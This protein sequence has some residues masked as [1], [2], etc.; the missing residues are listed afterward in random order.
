MEERTLA[1]NVIV[2]NGQVLLL[3]RTD[4]DYWELPGGTVEEGE[5]PRQAAAREA[6]EEMG[7]TVDVRSPIG[8]LDLDFEHEGTQYRFRGFAAD[9]V[10]GRPEP[11]E[12]RF[13]QVDW[14]DSDALQRIPLA[15]NLQET[16]DALRLLLIRTPQVER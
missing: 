4:K 13:G 15:P 3:Y 2:E 10:D 1:G 7:C 16:I 6:E 12:A 14:F 9:I 5:T 8:R 11:Q